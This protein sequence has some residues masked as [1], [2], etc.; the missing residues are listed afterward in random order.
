MRGVVYQVIVILVVI[1]VG[2]KKL[3]MEIIGF[4]QK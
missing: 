2:F 1:Q 4:Y 3:K